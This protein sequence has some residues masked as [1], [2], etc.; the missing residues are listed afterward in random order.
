[1]RGCCLRIAL[2]PIGVHFVSDLYYV[3]AVEEKAMSK[4]P[5]SD[6]RW[7][8]LWRAR[9]KAVRGK[10]TKRAKTTKE[11][12]YM[13]RRDAETERVQRYYNTEFRSWRFCR[14]KQCL[15]ARAC[16]GDPKAC[17]ARSMQRV[18]HREQWLARQKLME[19]TPLHIGAVERKVREKMPADFFPR[20]VD[21]EVVEA[22]ARA[23]ARREFEKEL[24]EL[25]NPYGPD[26]MGPRR[27]SRRK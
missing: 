18:P 23:Q 3:A 4:R 21:R 1:M 22:L 6:E 8:A 17:L 27:R 13:I 2:L 9:A 16:R 15:R 25:W 5:L 11:I 7:N 24:D 26:G 14:V 10:T 20:P 12:D 19:A